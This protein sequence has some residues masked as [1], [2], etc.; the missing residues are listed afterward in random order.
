MGTRH[1]L[2]ACGAL[3]LAACASEAPLPE[4]TP[5]VAAPKTQTA[6]GPVARAVAEHRALAQRYVQAGDYA[7]AARE[8]HIVLMLAPGDESGRTQLDAAHTAIRQGVRDN[9]QAGNSALRGGDAD[10]ASALMLK[11]LALDPSNAE[12]MK[13]LRDIDRQKLVRIQGNRAAKVNQ[14]NGAAPGR[15]PAGAAVTPDATESYD[16]DQRIEMF[17]AGD[18]NGGLHEFRAFVDANPNNLG[19]RQRIGTTVYERAQE[20]E[21]KGQREPALALYEQAASLRGG[22]PVPEWTAR[23]QALRKK[24]SDDFYEKGLQAY[25]TDTAAAIKLW[26]T[27][28]HYDPQNQK[29]TSRLQDAR[30]AQD[31]MKRIQGAAK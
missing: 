8:W 28:L 19:A 7:A 20:L 22:K 13:V 15:P 23:M 12:A 24:L 29:A 26:E 11:V 17:K 10:R 3:L 5:V 9:L 2:W 21:S 4:P 14:A 31:K 1:W 30:I 18:T 16:I 25:R 27:S 6:A